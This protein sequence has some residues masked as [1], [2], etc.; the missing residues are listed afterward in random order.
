[1]WAD[2]FFHLD[3]PYAD[4]W[5]PAAIGLG[6]GGMCVVMGRQNVWLG[7][8]PKRSTAGAKSHTTILSKREVRRKV[9]RYRAAEG[10][11]P[12]SFMLCRTRRTAQSVRG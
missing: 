5:V 6:V 10:I 4:L 11:P 1:M 2:Q 8:S 3:L 7:R 12:R 9:A